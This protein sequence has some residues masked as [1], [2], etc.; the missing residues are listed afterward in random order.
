MNGRTGGPYW[1]SFPGEAEAPWPC[2]P[3][4][5]EGAVSQ[6]SGWAAGEVSLGGASVAAT[7]FHHVGENEAGA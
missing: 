3:V 7:F 6:T 4:L 2:W 1:V 5:G